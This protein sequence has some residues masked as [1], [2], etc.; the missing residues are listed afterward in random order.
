VFNVVSPLVIQGC[1]RQS[2]TQWGLFGGLRLDNGQPWGDWNDLPKPMALWLV[3]LGLDL[4]FNPVCRPEY[5][6]VVEK[7]QD[8]GQ[9]WAEPGTCWSAG[10][11]QGRLDWLDRL[12]REEYP[13]LHGRSRLAV[14]PQLLH[15][16]RPYSAA[17]E[18]ELWDFGRA[19]EYLAG[20][21]AQRRANAQ[22]QV[23][24]YDH[25]YCVGAANRGKTVLVQY[26]PLRGSW[27]FADQEGRQLREVPADIITPERILKLSV[28]EK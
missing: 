10:Q 27:V 7:S 4:T 11:L 22:G 12:Q 15:A 14:F 6:G 13:S 19:Q 20:H 21:V 1:F 5:N 28:T 9:R 26:D 8:T 18:A 25:R 23:S 2:F 17:Q 3:G 16:A 24:V